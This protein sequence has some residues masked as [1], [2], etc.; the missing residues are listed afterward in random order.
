MEPWPIIKLT[1]T[2]CAT[3]LAVS[4]SFAL[5]LYLCGLFFSNKPEVLWWLSKID[6]MLAII[7]PTALAIMFLSSL[8]RIVLDALISAWKGFPNVNTHSI[9][10]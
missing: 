7:T 8:F 3:A 1:L 5:T 6:L 2:H 10:A 9:L 4:G